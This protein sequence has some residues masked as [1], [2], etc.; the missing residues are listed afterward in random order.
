[1]KKLG[2]VFLIVFVAVFVI[3]LAKDVI[4]KI[5][6]EKGTEL[7]TGLQLKMQGFSASIL[8]QV[9]GIRHLRLY[10][11]RGY[12][13]R[14]MLHMP[15][16]YLDYDLGA[17]TKGV[18]H[19]EE[20]RMDMKEFTVV[21]N[22][23]GELNLDSLKVVQ[24]EKQGSAPEARDKGKAPEIQ[25]DNLE[26]KIGKVIYKDYSGGRTPSVREFN[27]NLSE[28]YQNITNPYSLVSLIVVKALM[29]TR[30]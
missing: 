1:M 12:P 10:N 14:V 29:N 7:V 19:V 28:K 17:I 22:E 6:V 27:V 20:M 11:P 18:I 21:K 2:T 5:S 13:D 25:I 16:I 23:K 4:I 15:E 8:R 3:S 9:V 26:L 30:R 24:A